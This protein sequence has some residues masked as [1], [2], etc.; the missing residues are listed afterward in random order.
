MNDRSSAFENYDELKFEREQGF[1]DRSQSVRYAIGLL[2][3]AS[4]FFFLH[5]K[6]VYVEILELHST[7]SNYIVASTDFDFLDEAATAVLQ[8]EAVRDIGKIYK[9]SEQ[10][11]R[12]RRIEFENFLIYN[13]EWRHY[14]E[15]S[16]FDEMYT[17][18]DRLEKVMDQ[19]KFTDP[20]TL[21]KMKSISIPI[22]NYVIYTPPEVET[23]VL[24][25]TSVWSYL[26][27]TAFSSSFPIEP[28]VAG[29]IVGFFQQGSWIILEDAHEQTLLRKKLQ[30]LV[31]G[32]YTYV[33]AGSRIID[34]GEK[35]TTRHLAMLQAMKQALREKRNLWHPLTLLGSLILS[36]LLTGICIIYFRSN[37]PQILQSNRKMGL[38]ATIAI[39]TLA[40]A[41]VTQWVLLSSK[42]NLME[43]VRYPVFAAF[44]AILLSSLMNARVATFTSGFLT[45]VLSMG[46]SF[47]QQGFLLINLGAALAAILCTHSLRRRKEIFIICG[48]AWLCCIL[49]IF[50]LN[51]SQDVFWGMKVLMDIL[52]AGF[53]LLFTGVGVVGLLPLLESTFRVMTDVTLTEYLDPNNDLLHRLTIEAPGTYQHSVVVGNI[54]E[55][56]ALSIGANGLFCRVAT[57]YHDI[58]KM[59]TPQYFTENQQGGIDIH[60]LLTPQESAEVI[61]AHVSEGVAMARKA[62]LPE[63]FID[64]IKEHH[65]TTL[66]YYFYR[67]CLEK[68]GGDKTKINEAQFRY[69]G[70]K[71]RSKESGI[72]MIADTLEAASRSLDKITEEALT[73]LAHRLVREKVADGQLD[74]CLLTLEELAAVTHTLVKT[75][76][77][78][79]HSRIKYPVEEMPK[80]HSFIPGVDA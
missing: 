75:L 77:A 50:A 3:M 8:Q 18:V 49:L 9:L 2:F 68:A 31:P 24:L 26:Q 25:P 41:F 70:P 52:C 34:K 23:G 62:C 44:P 63:Q 14:V 6:E 20:R 12:Q 74:H 29:L 72:I 67:K 4:L 28:S 59:V 21:Q 54:A 10:E 35:V 55:T 61:I 80:E 51:L 13:Q 27:N 30:A 47:E 36:I 64:I 17:G 73:E 19:V 32:K 38:V 71:P 53:F 60:Q 57:L 78:F 1:F 76:V 66:V 45:I 46:L 7:A 15:A 56:A 58:G 42:T 16:T 33:R 11:V 39:T 43:F 65:G 40:V 22:E 5:F 37:H 79:G 48:K 69:T